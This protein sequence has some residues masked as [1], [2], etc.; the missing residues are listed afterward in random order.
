MNLK[1]ITAS[2]DAYNIGQ[3]IGAAI[4]ETVQKV[5]V[6]NEECVATEQQWAGSDYLEQLIAAARQ[7]FPG[8]VREMEGMA[9]GMGVDFQRVVLWNCRGDFPWP[10][11][12]SPSLASDLTHGC[13]SLIIPATD[14]QPAMI[15]HNEDGSS[16]YY[17]SCFWVSVKPDNAPG[18]ESFLYPGMIPGHTMGANHAGI[19]QTI[20]NIRV[21]DLK[22][23]VPRHFICR[24]I[25]D[26]T[27]LD[28]AIDLLQRTNRAAG[29]HHNLGSATEQRLASVE[30]P[31]SGCTITE[32]TDQPSAH[33]N[34]LITPDQKDKPQAITQS[35]SVR[36]HRAGELL[37]RNGLANSGP[38]A[39]L[40][41]TK[42]GQEI[43]R[44]PNDGSDDYGK[45]LSTGIFRLTQTGVSVTIHDGPA[46]QNTHQSEFTVK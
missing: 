43:L 37:S 16:D 32:I 38:T 27:S 44:S 34:H 5:T 2:G 28:D 21:H 15:A 39:I 7:A 46:N 30:A 13:T 19:V 41:D 26:C 25:L 9:D 23:G 4:A 3:T 31:A 35:S 45:T 33:A 1:I 11:N 17:G 24:A 8:Y 22:P 29:F 42:P 40:F 10:D 36:Q 18:F 14:D 20:N 6:H 12:I